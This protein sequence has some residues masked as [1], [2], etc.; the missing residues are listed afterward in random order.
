MEEASL[1]SGG[2][3]AA[4]AA[5]AGGERKIVR[6]SLEGTADCGGWWPG[7]LGLCAC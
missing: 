6:A 7:W 3:T 4:A 1:V 2:I 5:V